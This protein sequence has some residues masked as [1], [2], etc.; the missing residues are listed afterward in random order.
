M[1]CSM[2][3]SAETQSAFILESISTSQQIQHI[4]EQM[5]RESVASGT[6]FGVS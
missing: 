2:C 5:E 6:A 4:C 1:E 3:S